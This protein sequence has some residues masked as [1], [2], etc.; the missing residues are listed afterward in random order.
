MNQDN[1]R[2][3]KTKKFYLLISVSIFP[4]VCSAEKLAHQY[5]ASQLISILLLFLRAF[6][7][8]S[9]PNASIKSRK[10]KALCQK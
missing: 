3:L 2:K 4:A 8:I 5:S 7:T 1:Y 10:E 9:L 6:K